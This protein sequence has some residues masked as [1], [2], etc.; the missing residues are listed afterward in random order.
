MAWRSQQ[1]VCILIVRKAIDYY[2]SRASLSSYS[3]I[4]G[5]AATGHIDYSRARHSWPAQL[6]RCSD[7]SM[8]A[9]DH[10]IQLKSI[11]LNTHT[12]CMKKNLKSSV[13]L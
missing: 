12:L 2:Y 13:S 11:T 1:K 3:I 5:L 9:V 8:T 6:S 4:V 7:E 10:L